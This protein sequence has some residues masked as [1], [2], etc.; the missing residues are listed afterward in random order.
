MANKMH[1]KPTYEDL[2]RSVLEQKNEIVRIKK[3]LQ[4][5]TLYRKN[6]EKSN[7]LAF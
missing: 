2:R 4:K 7:I 3:E 6:I 5:E 1:K